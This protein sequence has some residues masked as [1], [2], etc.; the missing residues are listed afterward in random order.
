[1]ISQADNN[2]RFP[3]A[4]MFMKLAGNFLNLWADPGRNEK[5]FDRIIINFLYTSQTSFEKLWDGGGEG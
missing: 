3:I 4:S 5:V 2:S 1:M